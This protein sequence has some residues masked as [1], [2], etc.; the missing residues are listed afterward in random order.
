MSII[1][2]VEYSFKTAANNKVW[3]AETYH[4]SRTNSMTCVDFE[5]QLP[6]VC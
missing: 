6:E 4:E 1:E 5:F 3:A 2:H